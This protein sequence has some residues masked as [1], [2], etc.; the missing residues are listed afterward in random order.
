MKF[1]ICQIP[2]QLKSDPFEIVNIQE[3]IETKKKCIE[4]AEKNNVEVV[5]FPEYSYHPTEEDYLLQKS[6]KMIIFAG[7]YQDKNNFNMNM[8]FQNGELF[9]Q[10]K[11]NLS[12]YENSAFYNN[13]VVGSSKTQLGYIEFSNNGTKIKTLPLVCFDYIHYYRGQGI[14]FGFALKKENIQLVVSQ[15]CNNEPYKFFEYAQVHHNDYGFTSIFCNVSK[16]IIDG[17]E[18]GTYGKSSVFGLH[19]KNFLDSRHKDFINKNFS[20]MIMF[21]PEGEGV[22]II[23]LQ[24][25]YIITPALSIDYEIN[26][27][28]IKY[29]KLVDLK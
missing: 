1:L 9:N 17:E 24:I 11:I 15:C 14:D 29:T 4:Y 12:P 16:L 21:L 18:K 8:I 27:K 7:S 22:C 20:N 2:L 25:P 6:E 28:E 3:H 10:A 5:I 19:S 23:D 13:P 26:P